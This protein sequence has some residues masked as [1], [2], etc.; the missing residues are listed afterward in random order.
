MKKRKLFALFAT[1]KFSAVQYER[2]TEEGGF[3]GASNSIQTI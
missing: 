3:Y 2:K 1:F